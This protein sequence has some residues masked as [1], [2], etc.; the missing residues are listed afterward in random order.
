[1]GYTCVAVPGAAS[2]QWS[3]PAGASIASGQGTSTITVD[4]SGTFTGGTISVYAINSCGGGATRTLSVIG[5]PALPGTISG[6]T[7]TCANQLYTYEVQA[8]TGATAYTWVAP[9]FVQILSGQGTKT[10]N[11]M[12]GY[13]PVASFTIS[14]KASNGCG[15]SSLRKLENISTSVCPRIGSSTAFSAINVYPNPAHGNIFVA[16][17]LDADQQIDMHL[18]D[19][20]G[21]QVLQQR[22]SGIEGENLIPMNI[23]HLASGIYTLNIRGRNASE[24]IRIIVE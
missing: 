11:V 14:V 12:M 20:T 21:R 17:T 13:N 18:S 16:I 15:T 8:L 4:Y 23:S 9:S 1:M 6:A 22:I 2:Y 19:V 3:A 24:I 5:A 7:T 10:L